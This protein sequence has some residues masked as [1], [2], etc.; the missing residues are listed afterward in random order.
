VPYTRRSPAMTVPL[1]SA[2]VIFLLDVFV[3]SF[4]YMYSLL[5]Y[6]SNFIEIFIVREA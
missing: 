5:M 6:D 1:L 4:V 3:Y 2:W